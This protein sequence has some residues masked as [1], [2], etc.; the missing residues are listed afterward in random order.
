MKSYRRERVGQ[1]HRRYRYELI[2]RAMMDDKQ[3]KLMRNVGLASTIP[4]VLVISILIGYA[5]GSWLDR[6]FGT[7]PWLMLVFTVLGIA[8][9]F[10]EMFRIFLQIS[11]E[12]DGDRQ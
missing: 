11:K 1:K 5:L 3:R 7:E 12:D 6:V 2:A 4:W 9:G 10:I 8:A